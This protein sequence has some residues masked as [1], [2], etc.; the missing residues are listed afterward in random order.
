MGSIGDA[1]ETLLNWVLKLVVFA[2]IIQQ[3]IPINFGQSVLGAIGGELTSVH[4]VNK[5]AGAGTYEACVV[6]AL[7]P[8]DIG[9]QEALRA[10]SISNCSCYRAPYSAGC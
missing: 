4:P 3:F 1:Y 9:Y 6:A 10:L 7:L 5:I 8:T 2:W